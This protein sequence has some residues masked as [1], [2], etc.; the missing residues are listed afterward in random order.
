MARPS[1]PTANTSTG[2]TKGAA[3]SCAPVVQR[4]ICGSPRAWHASPSPSTRAP[5]RW[6]SR[7][8]SMDAVVPVLYQNPIDEE[9]SNSRRLLTGRMDLR[10]A[11]NQSIPPAGPRR[12]MPS[13]AAALVPNRD[14]ALAPPGAPDPRRPNGPAGPSSAPSPVRPL[15]FAASRPTLSCRSDGVSAADSRRK[16]AEGRPLVQNTQHTGALQSLVQKTAAP[17]SLLG[18]SFLSSVMP[19]RSPRSQSSRGSTMPSPQ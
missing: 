3:T 16:L 7:P 10:P 4:D 1:T 9:R 5:T 18:F 14:G 6:S 15:P 17:S 11:A 2:S 13:A 8:P 19:F 12:T